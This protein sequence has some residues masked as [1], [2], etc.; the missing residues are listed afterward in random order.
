MGVIV[1]NPQGW[2]KLSKHSGNPFLD[3]MT[4]LQDVF[5]VISAYYTH[6]P[7]IDKYS[8]TSLSDLKDKVKAYLP[9]A[10]NSDGSINFTKLEELANQGN[11]LAE[12]IVGVKQAREN[13][14]NSSLKGQLETFL[15]KDA[16][17]QLDILS[18]NILTK[19]ANVLR[20]QKEIEEKI[21][22]SNLPEDVKT[23]LLLSKGAIFKDPQTLAAFLPYLSLLQGQQP[24]NQQTSDQQTSSQQPT[25][26]N[27]SQ[28]LT[29]DQLINN[30]FKPLD[31]INTTTTNN[32]PSQTPTS[33]ADYIKSIIENNPS[34]KLTPEKKKQIIYKL[35][36]IVEAKKRQNMNKNNQTL[37]QFI[38]KPLQPLNYINAIP[39][40]PPIRAGQLTNN[41]TILDLFHNA[42]F[43]PSS[44]VNFN[45]LDSILG[46]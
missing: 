24:S 21:K 7:Y 17:G 10:I 18:G 12:A 16:Q 40:T 25:Q 36:K 28:A 5:S 2:D 20:N 45:M 8:D 38:N 23:M 3:A 15:N 37:E 39:Q 14:S 27:T 11:E 31:Y 42:I 1:V 43:N 44:I 29:I 46:R 4:D 30:P 32:T 26:D 34:Q 22:N 35:K 41:K 6:K 19:Q 9:E 33:E 13:F